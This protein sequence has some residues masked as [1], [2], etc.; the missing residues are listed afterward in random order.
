L[1]AILTELTRACLG[2]MSLTSTRQRRRSAASTAGSKGC[3]ESRRPARKSHRTDCGLAIGHACRLVACRSTAVQLHI[4]HASLRTAGQGVSTTRG[5][6]EINV[7]LDLAT[8]DGRTGRIDDA[9]G[10]RN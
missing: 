3:G 5:V 6:A 8:P 4:G 1:I 10:R 9:R 7:G 2:L